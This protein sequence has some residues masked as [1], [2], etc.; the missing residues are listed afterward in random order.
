MLSVPASLQRRA[1][2]VEGWLDL[3]CT[4]T[5]L[6]KLAPLLAVPGAR[7][8]GLFLSVRALV[9]L[10]DFALALTQLDELR[11]LHHEPEWF[12]L[13][14]A[15]CR[16]RT[17][18]I[19]GAAR[20][21]ERLIGREPRSAIGHFNLGCYLA[22]MGETARAIGLLRQACRLDA[23][24]RSTPLDDTDLDGLRGRPDFEALRAREVEPHA[25]DEETPS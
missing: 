23:S 19:Q 6:D 20:C 22:L 7:P 10:G 18:D 1:L 25:E 9:T 16:K 11:D 17:G 2:E 15:W 5:A 24:F 12:D 8:I 3:G 21:M 13:T 14:E 4:T